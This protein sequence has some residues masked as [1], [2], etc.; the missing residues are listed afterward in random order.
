MLWKLPSA[1]I[2]S[3]SRMQC[4]LTKSIRS[5]AARSE[6][7]IKRWISCVQP[8][9]HLSQPPYPSAYGLSAATCHTPPCKP[10]LPL[11]LGSPA[12]YLQYSRYKLLSFRQTQPT[13]L[14]QRV[15]WNDELKRTERSWSAARPLGTLLSSHRIL[16]KNLFIVLTGQTRWIMNRCEFRWLL[17]QSSSSL[18]RSARRFRR[19]RIDWD[20]YRRCDRTDWQSIGRNDRRILENIITFPHHR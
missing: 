2:T 3:Q 15:L 14:L 6:R 20:L 1:W 9:C 16:Q 8:D 10:A 4:P 12:L 11:T 19:Q 17:F 18:K 7:P 13:P 5:K